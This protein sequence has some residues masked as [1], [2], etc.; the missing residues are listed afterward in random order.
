MTYYPQTIIPAQTTGY[1]TK[2]FTGIASNTVSMV[3]L[4]L[5]N[6]E[7]INAQIWS[8]SAHTPL[9]QL[10]TYSAFPATGNNNTI[11][12]ALDTSVVY[13][14]NGTSYVSN[15]SGT[16]WTG[17]S[18]E[19]LPT[20]YFAGKWGDYLINGV[21]Q[22]INI[23]SP[24]LELSFNDSTIFRLIKSPTVN[25]VSVSGNPIVQM[26]ILPNGE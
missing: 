18:V 5:T 14:W 19:L 2:S 3:G 15:F 21:Q 26:G 1:I 25:M 10:A 8:S 6:N 11:Y 17:G 24:L 12:Q 23:N 22:Q 9:V 4:D 7:T 13:Y 20:P 16:I